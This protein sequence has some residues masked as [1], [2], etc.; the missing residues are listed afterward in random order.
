[1]AALFRKKLRLISLLLQSRINEE[2]A[3]SYRHP[4]P[5]KGYKV[6]VLA[7]FV[8]L[9]LR[10]GCPK[11]SL[12]QPEAQPGASDVPLGMNLHRSEKVIV[13]G[14]HCHR[15]PDALVE[16][17]LLGEF[18]A[19]LIDLVQRHDLRAVNNR[20]VQSGFDRVM[21]ED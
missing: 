10:W 5:N 9:A 6:S 12:L 11:K 19:T 16:D 7:T 18:A 20:H 1:M 8:T 3:H 17:D 21:Q 4:S 2:S 14:C 15:L 13:L